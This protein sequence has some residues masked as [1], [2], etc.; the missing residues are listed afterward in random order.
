MLTTV[1]LDTDPQ[2]GPDTRNGLK[3][4]ARSGRGIGPLTRQ[5]RGARLP[6]PRSRRSRGLLVRV[7]RLTSLRSVSRRAVLVVWPPVDALSLAPTLGRSR[8]RERERGDGSVGRRCR[9]TAMFGASRW[10]R[11][12]AFRS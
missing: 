5:T 3:L 12:S 9:K 11:V 1:A 7:P 8:R 2:A 10:R 4:A 6:R